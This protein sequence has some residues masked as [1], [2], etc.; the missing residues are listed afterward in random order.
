MFERLL[1]MDTESNPLQ[2]ENAELPIEVT[3]LGISTAKMLV[4]L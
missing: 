2:L 1:D 3:E 4:Q